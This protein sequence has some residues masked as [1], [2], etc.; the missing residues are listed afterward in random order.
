MRFVPYH[1]GGVLPDWLAG[2]KER[3]R[4]CITLG[5]TVPHVADNW[6]NAAM[7]ERNGIGL[8]R[9][10]E[11]VDGALLKT[12]ITDAVLRGTTTAFAATLA[13][14]PGP[15]ALVPRLAALTTRH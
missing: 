2:P 9:D 4:V 6:I 13:A 14:D 1:G 11:Q 10:P 3:P 7:V 12:L 5:T 15:D 8:S